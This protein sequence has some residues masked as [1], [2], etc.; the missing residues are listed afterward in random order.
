MPT[1]RD[2]TVARVF[3]ESGNLSVQH[4]KCEKTEQ[5]NNGGGIKSLACLIVYQ[6]MLRG[7]NRSRTDDLL[8]FTLYLSRA[9]RQHQ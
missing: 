3:V 7:Q 4:Q 5:L 6:D 9:V 8:P 1:T 2:Q